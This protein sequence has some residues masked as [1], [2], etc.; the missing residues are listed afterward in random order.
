MKKICIT[1]LLLAIIILTVGCNGNF[2]IVNNGQ[3]NQEFLRIHVRANSNAEQDQNVKYKIKDLVINWLTPIIADCHSK[4][5]TAKVISQNKNKLTYIID[6]VLKSNGFEYSSHVAIKNEVF[7]TR[8][9]EGLTLESG[10]YD[11]VIVELGK[12]Q[13][14]NWWCVVYPPLCFTSG[15]SVKYKSKILEIIE[16]FLNRKGVTQT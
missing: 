8:V 5:D 15:K 9:Y 12:A 3:N 2:K 1:F 16:E 14:D 10:Y 7:P 4:D 13:G 11:A 6:E